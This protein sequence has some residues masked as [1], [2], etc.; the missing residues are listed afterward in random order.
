MY[1]IARIKQWT[2]SIQVKACTQ[3]R[4]DRPPIWTRGSS[5]RSRLWSVSRKK[6][7]CLPLWVS[8]CRRWSVWL[9][10]KSVQ[11]IQ[12]EV[13]K[14]GFHRV[15]IEKLTE[16]LIHF[17]Y[18]IHCRPAVV[19]LTLWNRRF[20]QWTQHS[21][22]IDMVQ[23]LQSKM[24]KNDWIVLPLWPIGIHLELTKK[25][26]K[27]HRKVVHKH[28]LSSLEILAVCLPERAQLR[29]KWKAHTGGSPA[30][31]SQVRCVVGVAIWPT[32]TSSFIGAPSHCPEIIPVIISGKL[33]GSC[34]LFVTLIL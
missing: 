18:P 8:W 10:Q 14:V 24:Y 1:D 23:I 13:L 7:R 12:G 22:Y 3:R 6:Q 31:S 19:F 28:V 27:K 16:K 26:C 9:M 32:L 15:L 2:Y 30:P 20:G 17:D 21:V 11:T 34:Y 5:E 25:F 4:H 29:D 33:Q